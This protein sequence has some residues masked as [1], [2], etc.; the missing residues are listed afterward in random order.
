MKSK[1]SL[2]TGATVLGL[3]GIFVKIMGAG[4]RL[5]LV[6]WIGDVG[7]AN[8]GPAYYI[9]TFLIIIATSGIPVAISKMVSESIA[10][11]N[12]YQ[13]HKVFRISAA[14]MVSLGLF[15]FL[16]LFTFAPQ[17]AGWMNNPDSAL[18]MRT[19]APALM[20]VPLMA[21]FRGYFQ[22]MQNMRPT[23]ISQ[24]V[25][26][27]F[28]VVVGLTCAYYFFFIYSSSGSYD[29]YARGAAGANFGATAGTIGGLAM[30]LLIYAL[31][32]KGITKRID[33]SKEY[34]TEKGSEILKKILIIAVPITIGAAVLPILNLVDTALV[35]NRLTSV[36]GFSYE[37][38][39]SLYG[40]LSGFV[41]SLVG[42]PQIITQ[43]VGVSMVP[44]IAAAYKTRNQ[45]EIDKNV[46]LGIRMSVLIGFPSAIGLIILSK[47]I[48]LM[49]YPRQA[50][51]A[52]SAAHLLSIM[53][54]GLIFLSMAITLTGIL[55]GI[56]KQFIPVKNL[57][58]AIVIKI[59]LTWFLVGI[60]S[61]NVSG[62]AIGT[63]AAYSVSVTLNFIAVKKYTR[64]HISTKLTFIKPM[65][66]A[67]IMGAVVMI[68]YRL[69]RIISIGNSLS[70]LL[71]I[72]IGGI[73]YVAMIFITGSIKEEE[74][75]NI[76][77]GDK[78]VRL[79][80]KFKK[81]K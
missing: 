6:N 17:I 61:I 32:H 78:I 81:V 16:I 42:L 80:N 75:Y 34:G 23:A 14:L 33:R 38:A 59:V 69:L 72:S 57:M 65:T 50:E 54:F 68:V 79:V 1:Q 18:G 43:A 31:A 51:S 7:M 74:L 2:I 35:M 20:L 71:S 49:L 41:D 66:S 9:Y 25:E 30:I 11:G 70:T 44:I 58:I 13:A 64:T 27:F 62:A 26:Q 29:K 3:A 55:Q 12:Y 37:A 77:K 76:P 47:P 24:I 73:V 46:S 5:P 28:R 53:A 36:A 10:L 52:E 56:G 45:Q 67:L 15:F 48:L 40:Q 4:F 8:Y 60:P 21:A 22:G 39:K 63:V 19:I